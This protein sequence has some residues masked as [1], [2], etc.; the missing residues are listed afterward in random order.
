MIADAP[1]SLFVGEETAAVALH[2]ML[3]ALPAKATVMGYLETTQPGE[4][5]PYT[6]QHALPWVYRHE[7]PAT[8]SATLIE[9]VRSLALPDTPGVAYLAGE[10]LTC[11]AVRRYLMQEKHWPR[12]AIRVK[13]FWTPGKTGLD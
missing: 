9:A 2:S 8:I 12:T 10:A 7:A 4:E 11:Q 13:P 1:Y 3:E 6:G 5:V